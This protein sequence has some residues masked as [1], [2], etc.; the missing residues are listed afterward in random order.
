[1]EGSS[2]SESVGM[3]KKGIS[4]STLKLI[5]IVTMLIDHIGAVILEPLMMRGGNTGLTGYDPV[6]QE[7]DMVLRLVI[8]R[9]AFPIFCFMLVEGYLRTSNVYR[10]GLRLLVFALVSEF[11][12][13][14]ALSGLWLES[15][16]Q[17]VM[18][19]LLIGLAVMILCGKLETFKWNRFATIVAEAVVLMLGISAAE[20]LR[21][22]YGGYG[23]L[24]IAVLY[25]FRKDRKWQLVAGTVAFL[26]GDFLINGSL[27]ELFAPLGFLA[28]A[29]YDGRRGL[30]LKYLF[31]VFYPAH[32][33]VLYFVRVL[34]M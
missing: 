5:A 12:F 30:K 18:F 27:N 25:F 9:V 21:T 10:Y 1:M 24:C 19:T 16:Y 20:V 15:G 8:G 33:L 2:V 29:C 3:Q 11:A 22:D 17:N 13:D 31:Y 14:L 4:S 7:V 23:V 6:L 34:L 32:L 26:A 28:V